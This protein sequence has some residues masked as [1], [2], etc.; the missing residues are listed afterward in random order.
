MAFSCQRRPRVPGSF[1]SRPSSGPDLVQSDIFA[2]DT[3]ILT[4][5]VSLGHGLLTFQVQ[6]DIVTWSPSVGQRSID[7]LFGVSARGGLNAG[8][9][10]GPNSMSLICLRAG[11]GGRSERRSTPH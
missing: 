11:Q 3:S 7:R 10:G 4:A 5:V 6:F 9:S 1:L 8:V 2:Q